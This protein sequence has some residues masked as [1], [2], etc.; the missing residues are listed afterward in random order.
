MPAASPDRSILFIGV[1]YA[2]EPT[3]ISPYTTGMAE[4]LAGRG[5]DVS[6]ITSFPHYPWWRIPAEYRHLPARDETNGVR[7]RRLR[8]YIPHRPST[9][10]RALFELSFGVRAL[11]TRWRSPDVV[12]VISPALLASRLVAA[13]ARLQGIPVV[14]W[15]Q[16]IYTLGV[17]QASSGRGKGLIARVERSLADASH[18]VV[19][20]HDRFR[21]MFV[22]GVGTSAPIDVVRNWSH[23]PDVSGDRRA[24]TRGRMHWADDD[25]IV[26]H[27]GAMGA[28]QGLENVV[29]A[30]REATRR[31]SRVRF[32]LLGDGNQREH[33]ESLGADPRLDFVD[34]LP[35]DRFLD[36]LAAADVLL[37]NE[38]PGL[39]EMSV[40]SK[41]TT[42]FATGL[43]VVA[44]VDS[45]STT[46]DEVLASGAGPVVAAGDPVALVDAIEALDAQPG[47]AAS[48]GASGRAYRAA[49]LTSSAAINA[50]E[51][52]LTQAITA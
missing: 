46:H 31:G 3:G 13:R 37:A 5:H 47:A 23:V 24:E 38:R 10:R 51:Q 21:S 26:L 25:V 11:F 39:T 36:T 49:H 43:P 9:I 20:I 6:V 33:L 7:V 35:D 16:D 17:G 15:V 14:T 48:Y 42:Y 8:H 1:N 30:A 27:A 41:L 22:E 34:P 52:T 50:F 44:A 19:V 32:V 40:P 12:V 18:R 45:S 29:Y 2:P 28:K 4:G